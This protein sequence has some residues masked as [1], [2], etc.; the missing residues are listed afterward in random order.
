VRR[1]CWREGSYF[2]YASQCL[3]RDF[4]ANAERGAG[5]ALCGANEMWKVSPGVAVWAGRKT[6]T[7]VVLFWWPVGKKLWATVVF[8]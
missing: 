5:L 8:S 6:C 3:G 4:V 1:K 7:I 2:A